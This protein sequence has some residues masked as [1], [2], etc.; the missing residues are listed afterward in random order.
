MNH[1]VFVCIN[2]VNNDPGSSSGWTDRAVTW[3][4]VNGGDSVRAEKFEYFTDIL[5][6]RLRQRSRA[7]QIAKMIGY[8]R[9]AGFA[10][11]LIGHSNG[12]DLVARVMRD[13]GVEVDGIHLVA[14][15]CDASDIAE[16]IREGL[17]K[18]VWLYGSRHDRAL[19]TAEMSRVFIGWA[20]LG[21]GSLGRHG[22]AFAA[23]FPGVVRD[24]SNDNYGHSTWFTRGATFE[25]T[26]KLIMDNTNR[27]P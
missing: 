3:L 21:Y 7:D 1:T 2:G 5:F 18:R 23:E 11:Y 22:P 6:R 20:G 14:A 16:S 17:V 9:R 10:V 4:H 26:M 12:C 15:A 27:E 13:A 19:I 8:Y 25:H 24:Y